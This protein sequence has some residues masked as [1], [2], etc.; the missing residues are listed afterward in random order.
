MALW[1]D[2]KAA[3]KASILS[4]YDG[5]YDAV[6]DQLA[7]PIADAVIEGVNGIPT[8]D[9]DAFHQSVAGEIAG[10]SAPGVGEGDN[11]L[12][13]DNSASNAKAR[14]TCIDIGYRVMR[15]ANQFAG[16]TLK[17]TPAGGD[18]FLMEDSAASNAKKRITWTNILNAIL[19]ATKKRVMYAAQYPSTGSNASSIYTYWV[20]LVGYCYFYASTYSTEAVR[21]LPIPGP[22]NI[23]KVFARTSESYVNTKTAPTVF[24]LRKNS[25]DVSGASFSIP[26]NAPSATYYQVTGS[27]PY[28]DA[29][30][31]CLRV[32]STVTGNLYMHDVGIVVEM[33]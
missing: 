26:A 8:G 29:D 13:E 32:D 11:F 19:G 7:N 27:W 9:P 5:A 30:W 10:L 14:G 21:N 16:L 6:A 25:A 24:Q 28:N 2:V 22:G 1:D 18:H 12:M 15:I 31:M 20:G 3:A 4:N 33:T 23:I 17:S